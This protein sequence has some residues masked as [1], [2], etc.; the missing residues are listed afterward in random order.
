M[1]ERKALRHHAR[2]RIFFSDGVVEGEGVVHD[3]SKQG[4]RVISETLLSRGVECELWLF[5]ADFEWPLKIDKAVVRWMGNDAFGAEFLSIG[6][7]QRE[8]LRRLIA[9]DKLQAPPA[10][11]VPSRR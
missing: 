9:E 10:P 5:S 1:T 11:D 4:C 6:G 7:A 2:I 3:L 8:R